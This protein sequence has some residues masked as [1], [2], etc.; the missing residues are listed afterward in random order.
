MNFYHGADAI[1][2]TQ[3]FFTGK[4]VELNPIFEIIERKGLGHPD[5]IA[6]TLAS[7]ISKHYS[8]YTISNC[9]G[10]ILHHQIDKLMIIGGRTLVSWGGGEFIEPIK[11]IV[12]G[13]ASYSF[14]TKQIPVQEIINQVIK[15][16][17]TKNF[18]M[19]NFSKDII[20]QNELTQSPGPGTLIESKGAIKNMFSP[21]N[22]SEIRGY[23]K[24]VANDTSYCVGFF[25]LTSLEKC[26]LGC[27]KMLNSKEFKNN[28][29]WLGSDIKIMAVRTENQI[30][31]TTCIP[32]IAAFVSSKEQYKY[33]LDKIGKIILEF[34]SSYFTNNHA[35]TISMNT[36][37]DYEKG[38]FYLTVSGASL[39]GDIGVVG[40]GNR[41]N[42]LICMNRPMSM[43]GVSGKNPRYYSGFIYSIFS[44]TLS[45]KIYN[46]FHIPNEI[47]IVSQNGGMLLNP[48][49]III[50]CDST[51]KKQVEEFVL[52]ECN[53]IN[54]VTDLFLNSD[55]ASC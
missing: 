9:E 14:G 50:N 39:S 8:R 15:D 48:W 30:D 27:E 29:N 11:I 28:N 31:I 7:E 49:K 6:D 23:E 33:N 32:Q 55:L 44:N 52:E 35:I 2:P 37:D 10:F 1:K 19:I 53:H 47:G 16:F 45:E 42:G 26:V 36:K 34:F 5:T 21:K 46:S 54:K 4:C 17:F 20:I 18:P 51:A 41:S 25:P 22:T 38:N 40:R 12:A 3:L 43:E 24:Y 13:R